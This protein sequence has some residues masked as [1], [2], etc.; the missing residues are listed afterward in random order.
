[1][2]KK[3]SVMLIAL[4]AISI[5]SAVLVTY[6]SNT[7][8]ESITVESPILLEETEF[9]LENQIGTAG[10]DGFMLVKIENLADSDITGDFEIAISPDAAGISIAVGEDINY[11]FKGQ[12]DMT[13]V[14]DCET[15][16]LVWMANNIDWNDWY[17]DADYLDATY[18]SPLVINHGGDSF[19]NLGYTGN[20]LVLPGLTI[21]ANEIVYGVIYVSTDIAL[22]PTTY[23]FAMT[24][25]P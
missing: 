11:C 13:R 3:L 8:S 17:A 4:L 2:K 22:T 5:V 21:P 23:T 12:G 16:Y 20:T 14:T 10:E 25:V 18:P 15:D 19:V 9:D 7:V 1:M 6:L 24:F